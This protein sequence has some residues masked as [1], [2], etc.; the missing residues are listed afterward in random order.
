MNK[1]L[2]V[3]LLTLS[4]FANAGFVSGAVGGAVSG[5]VVAGS[6]SNKQTTTINSPRRIVPVGHT[7][8]VCKLDMSALCYYKIDNR[9]PPM[10]YAAFHG[11]KIAHGQ[12]LV[13]CDSTSEHCLLMEV[14]K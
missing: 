13:K 1:I 5:A 10:Q 6:V 7:I 3:A 8:L 14:S 12:E 4:G 2:T 11:F 9:L